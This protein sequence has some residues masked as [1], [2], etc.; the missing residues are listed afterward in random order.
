MYFFRNFDPTSCPICYKD[1]LRLDSI[2]RHVKTAHQNFI[3]HLHRELEPEV[4]V[5]KYFLGILKSGD[6]SHEIFKSFRSKSN[7]TEKSY[8]HKARYDFLMVFYIIFRPTG[9]EGLLV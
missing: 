2:I 1:F 4:N 3:D 6:E 5:M 9:S 7:S 8:F